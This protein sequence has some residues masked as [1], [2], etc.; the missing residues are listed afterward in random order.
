[1][2]ERGVPM[3]ATVS[4]DVG[5]PGYRGGMSATLPYGSWPSVITAADLAAASPRFAGAAFVGEEIWWD[6]GTS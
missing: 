1:M 5:A 6:E 2:T 3:P 4:P